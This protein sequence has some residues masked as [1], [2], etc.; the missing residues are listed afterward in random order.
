[1]C[2]YVPQVKSSESLHGTRQLNVQFW[3]V[4]LVK[5]GG[6]MDWNYDPIRR[7]D[8]LIKPWH[9]YNAAAEHSISL[10]KTGITLFWPIH[11]PIVSR[12]LS[13]PAIVPGLH[14]VV[15]HFAPIKGDCRSSTNGWR[16][17]EHEERPKNSHQ[18]QLLFIIF[19][20]VWLRTAR[21]QNHFDFF[22]ERI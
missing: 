11:A 2:D 19:I 22:E 13:I 8:P 15:L 14:G 3:R 18:V 16:V 6:I 10:I 4:S 17:R 21:I 1:M 9:P 12:R 7:G 20:W 5:L